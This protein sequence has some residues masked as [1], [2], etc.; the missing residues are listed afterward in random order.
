M[1]WHVLFL[2]NLLAIDFV[3]KIEFPQRRYGYLFVRKLS[4]EE[5]GT[6]LQGLSTP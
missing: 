2:P 1:R 3:F 4:M 6:L 5:D